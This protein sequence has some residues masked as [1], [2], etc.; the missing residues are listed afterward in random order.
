LKAEEMLK[1]N[2]L[3]RARIMVLNQK[4]RSFKRNNLEVITIGFT[5]RAEELDKYL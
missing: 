5:K 2:I 3:L 4:L 1:T